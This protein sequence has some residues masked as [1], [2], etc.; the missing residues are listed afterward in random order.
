MKEGREEEEGAFFAELTRTDGRGG[1]AEKESVSRAAPEGSQGNYRHG[2]VR[3][4]YS[5]VG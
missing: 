4:S 5:K 1:A 2:T 3:L